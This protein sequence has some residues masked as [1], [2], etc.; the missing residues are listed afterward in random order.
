MH[1]LVL[2]IICSNL[3]SAT[4]KFSCSKSSSARSFKKVEQLISPKISGVDRTQIDF[5]P[6]GSNITPNFSKSSVKRIETKKLKWELDKEKQKLGSYIYKSHS[7]NI[8]DYSN[9]SQFHKFIDK[10]KE[11]EF[12][13][14][15][16]E[17]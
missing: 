17:K 4:E 7:N 12:F 1:K 15:N 9:D 10:I 6:N 8:Y 11:I 14:K 13:L 3:S 2:E 5:F 16:K